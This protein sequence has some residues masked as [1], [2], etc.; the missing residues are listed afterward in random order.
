MASATVATAGTSK[1][2]GR[3]LVAAKTPTLAEQPLYLFDIG[4]GRLALSLS[5]ALDDFHQLET[6]TSDL[7]LSHRM[8]PRYLDVVQLWRGL[9]PGPLLDLYGQYRRYHRDRRCGHALR[10]FAGRLRFRPFSLPWQRRAISPD[11]VD[12]DG[13]DLGDA[14]PLVFDVPLVRLVE[15]LSA[16]SGAGLSSPSPSTPS[17]CDS[18]S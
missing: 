1:G 2:K 4:A 9:Q 10:Q 18:F 8:D 11:A 13:A 12:D 16:D 3:L 6:Q 17:Y 14:D 7:H 15:F 5:P